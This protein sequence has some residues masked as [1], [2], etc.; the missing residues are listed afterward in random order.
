MTALSGGIE[1]FNRKLRLSSMLDWRGG[2]LWYNNTERIRCVSRLNCNGL[3]NPNAS[4]E[5][6]AMVVA[7]INNPLKTL[8]GFLQSGAF[9]KWRE[10]SAVWTLS[11]HMASKIRARSA[12]IVFTARNLHTWTKYRGT[13]PESDY[14]TGEGGDAPAEFQTFAAPTYFTFRLNLGF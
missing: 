3:N 8:D 12:S 6:Q 10:A 4:F 11:D 13:S 1:L 7:T 14:T 9:V 2:N 5:E